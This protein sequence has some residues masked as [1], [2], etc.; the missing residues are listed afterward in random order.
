MRKKM[1]AKYVCVCVFWLSLFTVRLFDNNGNH[2]FVYL[3]FF[4][5]MSP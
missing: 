2:A 4:F 3:Q 1:F 5:K